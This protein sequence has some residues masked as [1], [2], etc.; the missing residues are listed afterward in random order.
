M[1]IAKISKGRTPLGCIS[2]VLGKEGAVLHQTNCV[3]RT[4]EAL[5]NEFELARQAQAQFQHCGRKTE[6][7]VFHTSIGFEIGYSGG[8]DQKLEIAH[9][10]L[11]GMGF[12]FTQ[13]PCV[14]AEHH[15]TTHQHLHVIA[16]RVGWDGKTLS[17]W[18]DFQRAEAIMRSIEVEYGLK[19]IINSRDAQVKAPTVGEVRRSRWSGAE[20]PRV[21]IQQAIEEY[22]PKCRTLEKLTQQLQTQGITLES[23]PITLSGGTEALALLFRHQGLTFSASKLGKRYTYRGLKQN[24]GIDGEGLEATPAIEGAA[25]NVVSKGA[26]IPSLGSIASKAI[27][28]EAEGVSGFIDAASA[29]ARQGDGLG[30]GTEDLGEAV[31]ADAE[32]VLLQPDIDADLPYVADSSELLTQSHLEDEAENEVVDADV[33]I[34]PTATTQIV[35]AESDE[36]ILEGDLAEPVESSRLAA[37]PAIALAEAAV[38]SVIEAE[39]EAAEAEISE[40]EEEQSVEMPLLL[41]KADLAKASPHYRELWKLLEAKTQKWLEE[42]SSVVDFRSQPPAKQLIQVALYCRLKGYSPKTVAL[43]MMQSPAVIEKSQLKAAMK[44]QGKESDAE[45]KRI[46]DQQKLTVDKILR[47]IDRRVGEMERSRV[48]AASQHGSGMAQ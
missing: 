7:T 6:Q 24:F 36:V 39:A 4:P 5:A 13:N 28:S 35:L 47:E 19:P 30:V 46:Q 23:K 3:S 16:S 31:S 18:K 26:V 27:A 15:D 42:K 40:V 38:S 44:S 45:V 1:P 14:I 33:G 11:K 21:A 22:A 41:A 12:D 25:T 34:E 32:G 10:Y 37:A 20:I 8:T 9:T 2:Y 17:C 48:R 29:V 43:A